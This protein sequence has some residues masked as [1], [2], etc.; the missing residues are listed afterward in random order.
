MLVPVDTFVVSHEAIQQALM[1]LVFGQ[2]ALMIVVVSTN[3]ML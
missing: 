2:V 1:L 3:R